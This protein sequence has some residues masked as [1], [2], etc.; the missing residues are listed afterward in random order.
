MITIAATLTLNLPILS[1]GD[2]EF[3][4]GQ[5]SFIMLESKILLNTLNRPSAVLQTSCP[6]SVRVSFQLLLTFSSW[7]IFNP[8]YSFCIT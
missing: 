1:S 6:F 7:P 5:Y 4:E 2:L 3:V 8:G